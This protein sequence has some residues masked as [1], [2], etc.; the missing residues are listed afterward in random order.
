MKKMLLFLSLMVLVLSA[1]GA[2][3]ED[4]IGRIQT[5]KGQAEIERG[6]ERI[7]ASIGLPLN[8]GDVVRT[9]KDGGLGLV[10][11]DDTSLALGSNSGMALKQ[12]VFHPIENKFSV[13][14]RMVKG[15]FV[16][17]S[18]VISKLAPE[19]VKLETP[20]STIKVHGTRLLIE[21]VE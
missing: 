12:F 7:A 3:A 18:G 2:M 13:I 11:W 10:L 19:A 1:T 5:L 8:Q 14:L 20:A 15:A 4:V 17:Q 21:I 6:T 9:G 16:Y